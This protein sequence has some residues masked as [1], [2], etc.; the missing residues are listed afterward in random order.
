[1]YC[2]EDATPEHKIFTCIRWNVERDGNLTSQNIIEGTTENLQKWNRI[3]D[4]IR[5]VIRKKRRVQL[6]VDERN[7]EETS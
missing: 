1:M 2:D 7:L 4:F 3:A 5:K 6:S